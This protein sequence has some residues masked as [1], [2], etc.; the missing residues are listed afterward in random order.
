M[1]E[2]PAGSK[3]WMFEGRLGRLLDIA[4]GKFVMG[5]Q[6]RYGKVDRDSGTA[7]E[8]GRAGWEIAR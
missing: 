3:A 6:C 8:K 4:D 1:L 5:D 7:H 2:N